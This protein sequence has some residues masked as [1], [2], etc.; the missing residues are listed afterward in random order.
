[1]D[2][3]KDLAADPE[4]RGPVDQIDRPVLIM[5]SAAL[6]MGGGRSHAHT[7]WKDKLGSRAQG[8]APTP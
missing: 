6:P 3:G 2:G 8:G 5:R 1:M 7:V 4:G